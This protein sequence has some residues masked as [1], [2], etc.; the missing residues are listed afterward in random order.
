LAARMKKGTARKIKDFYVLVIL[1]SNII[2]VTRG[3]KNN[4]GITETASAK[5][6]GTRS[7]TRTMKGMNRSSSTTVF[8]I[9]IIFIY[10]PIKSLQ[11]L[12]VRKTTHERPVRGTAM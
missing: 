11:K 2:G 1:W 5:L 12:S 3:S 8:V 7:K 6:T 10:R 9:I 4:I